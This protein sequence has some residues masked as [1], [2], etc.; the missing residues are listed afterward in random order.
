[1]ICSIIQYS[2]DQCSVQNY[3]FS[4]LALLVV[5]ILESDSSVSLGSSI[6]SI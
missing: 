2:N 1:M 3:F 4:G 6:R 5:L